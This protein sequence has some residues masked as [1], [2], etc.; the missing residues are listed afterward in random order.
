I[1]YDV[2]G[3]MQVNIRVDRE[4]DS[5]LNR[6]VFDARDINLN[7]TELIRLAL[8]ELLACEDETGFLMMVDGVRQKIM[9]SRMGGVDGC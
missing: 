3:T 7:R 5:L 8:T 1:C 6:V 2:Q 4:I 9:A